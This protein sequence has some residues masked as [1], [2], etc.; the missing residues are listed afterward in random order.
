MLCHVL[1]RQLTRTTTHA[2]LPIYLVTFLSL[3]SRACTNPDPNPE[4]LPLPL[5]NP[6]PIPDP[7]PQGQITNTITLAITITT[8]STS[9]YT[10]S[11][12]ISPTLSPQYT[13]SPSLFA[14]SILNTTNLYRWEHSSP[15]LYWNSTLAAFAQNYSTQCIWQHSTENGFAPASQT[16]DLAL[17]YG[18]NLARGYS[19]VTAAVQA[20]G[21]ERLL[22]SFG[23]DAANYTGFSE[24]TGHFTQ[25]V[26]RDSVCVGCGWT[27]CGGRNGIDGVLLVCEYWPAGNVMGEGNR[28][29]RQNVGPQVRGPEGFDVQQATAGVTGGTA[30]TRSSSA[31]VGTVT[32][33]VRSAAGGRTGGRVGL[34]VGG[35]GGW[36]GVLFGLG[37]G[38]GLCWCIGYDSCNF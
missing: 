15:F 11:Q 7:L 14:A 23:S 16:E 8:T 21:D 38:M 32:A 4:P 24:A 17:R 13:E 12:T 27:D 33:S 20:W 3:V 22:F 1:T 35:G 37:I 6:D 31:P 2:C 18:E 5:P 26:W 19:N 36:G 34:G 29:F 28:W 9:Y 25:L 30:T 10:L